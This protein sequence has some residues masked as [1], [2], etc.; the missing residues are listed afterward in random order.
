MTVSH[1]AKIACALEKP[2]GMSLGG[3][4]AVFTQLN[5]HNLERINSTLRKKV[6]HEQIATEQIRHHFSISITPDYIHVEEL[7]YHHVFISYGGL[8]FE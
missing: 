7:K 1:K 3:Q 5:T 2:L 8:E 6:S 4:V